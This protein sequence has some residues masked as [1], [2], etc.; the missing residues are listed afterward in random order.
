MVMV[1]ARAVTSPW[2]STIQNFEHHE[3]FVMPAKGTS[4]Q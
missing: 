3:T 2:V 4:Y 1:G